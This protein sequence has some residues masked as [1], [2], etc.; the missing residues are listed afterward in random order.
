M[1][2]RSSV[3]LPKFEILG[4]PVN[5]ADDYIPWLIDR[6]QQ[7][8]GTHV[9]TMNAE[10]VMQA[11]HNPELAA[12]VQRADLVTPDG[13]GIIFALRLHG[14]TQRRYAGIELGED[15]LRTVST[16]ACNYPVFF[17]G[18]KLEVVEKAA[19]YWQQELPDLNIVGIQHGY[20][21]SEAQAQLK[22]DIVLTQPKIIFVAMGVPRQEIWIR[23]HFHLCPEA[24]WVGVGGSFDVW[25]GVKKRAPQLMRNLN[26]E[27]CY[28]IAQEPSRWQRT[29]ALPQ[30]ALLALGEKIWSRHKLPST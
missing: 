29:F 6:L 28:R 9:V 22:R 4:Q 17:Y 8:I 2:D 23:D 7:G 24:I 5:L 26:L 12:I 19:K 13:S 30:F 11:N 14:I 20:I 10:I 16:P 3:P 25:S 21:D 15:L 1:L 27:W 18:G